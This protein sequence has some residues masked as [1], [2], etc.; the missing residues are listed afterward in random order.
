[1]ATHQAGRKWLDVVIRQ[2]I[3]EVDRRQMSLNSR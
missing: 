2:P 1:M 3:D